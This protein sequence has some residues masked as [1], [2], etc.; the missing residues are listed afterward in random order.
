MVS[1]RV[2]AGYLGNACLRARRAVS[3]SM[4]RIF[5]RRCSL[6]EPCLRRLCRNQRRERYSACAWMSGCWARPMRRCASTW[7]CER[8]FASPDRS[9]SR[10]RVAQHAHGRYHVS[11]DLA[12]HEYLLNG[13]NK[14]IR[15]GIYRIFLPFIQILTQCRTHLHGTA[16]RISHIQ[17]SRNSC[18]ISTVIDSSE[19]STRSASVH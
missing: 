15:T 7:S 17:T 11:L 10:V 12:G 2:K 8:R 5:S 4:H 14:Y 18:V 3:L 1:Y 16:L 13:D 6:E 9:Q 19:Y